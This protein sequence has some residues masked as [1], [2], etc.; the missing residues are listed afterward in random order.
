M[1]PP[2]DPLIVIQ[3]QGMIGLN[4]SGSGNNEQIALFIINCNLETGFDVTFQFANTCKFKSG[5]REI[6]ITNLI[7]D[8]IS[9]TLGT[10]L[11]KAIDLDVLHNLAGNEYVWNPGANQ[12]TETVNYIVELRASW[13]VPATQL[14]GFYNERIT[15]IISH[16]L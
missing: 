13:T 8:E 10:G 7:L 9:G 5:A 12:T 11:N 3:S 1:S 6:P 4:F 14:A 16:G 15:V 2:D